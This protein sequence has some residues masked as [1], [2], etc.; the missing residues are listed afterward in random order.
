MAAGEAS[1]AAGWR[2]LVGGP[3]TYCAR[4]MLDHRVVANHA[5]KFG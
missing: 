4:S 1:V 2:P 5:F 3:G